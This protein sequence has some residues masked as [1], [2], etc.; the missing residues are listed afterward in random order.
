MGVDWDL[1]NYTKKERIRFGDF[2][3]SR[4]SIIQKSPIACAIITYYLFENYGDQIA[5]VP[6]V[7]YDDRPQWPFPGDY[8]DGW[9]YTDVTEKTIA[10]LVK[11]NV[12]RD[13]IAPENG[14]RL[15]RHRV[16]PGDVPY[17][18]DLSSE[19][20]PKPLAITVG[21]FRR[22]LVSRIPF[23]GQAWAA[24]DKPT[25][26]SLM[27]LLLRYVEDLIEQGEE[28]G[29][30]EV[31]RLI[32]TARRAF[33]PD[34]K[35]AFWEYFLDELRCH[36]P[37]IFA[38]M[39]AIPEGE[40]E[41]VL[42]ARPEHHSGQGGMA[43]STPGNQKWTVSRTLEVS[44]GLI[45]I[46]VSANTENETAIANSLPSWKEVT[47]QEIMEAV[48]SIYSEVGRI[49][50]KGRV[51][52]ALR[53]EITDLC[54]VLETRLKDIREAAAEALRAAVDEAGLVRWRK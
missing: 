49:S 45:T 44:R 1:F 10:A 48:Q 47:L 15:L 25:A 5:V 19:D 38:I 28:G 35:E 53:I 23:L 7:P 51:L 29:I 46:Q 18:F 17:I 43:T 26:A 8:L 16:D 50:S 30:V 41:P 22:I 42:L 14:A 34:L 32:D 39:E 6:D 20:V 4:R 2:V 37:R 9:Q 33:T 13:D 54:P 11:E 12:L 27:T 21:R 24:D 40:R 3:C 36:D 31:F 52:G